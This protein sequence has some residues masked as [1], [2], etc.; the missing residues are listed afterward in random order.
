MP[1]SEAFTP[2][3]TKSLFSERIKGLVCFPR[4]IAWM[5]SEWAVLTCP[6]RFSLGVGQWKPQRLLSGKT[7]VSLLE[8]YSSLGLALGQEG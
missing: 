4:S 7:S 6:A 3:W 5:G 1:F 2:G 8:P